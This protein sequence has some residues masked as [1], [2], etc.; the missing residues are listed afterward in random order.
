MYYFSPLKGLKAISEYMQN[1]ELTAHTA[2]KLLYTT[3]IPKDR[4]SS[5]L[6]PEKAYIPQMHFHNS[7]MRVKMKYYPE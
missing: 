1:S 5:T 4:N 6:K 3:G 7:S 2:R